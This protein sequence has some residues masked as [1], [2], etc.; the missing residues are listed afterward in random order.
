[1]FILG[2]YIVQGFSNKNIHV[3]ELVKLD[4]V[5]NHIDMDSVFNIKA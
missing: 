4:Q 5:R 1:M 3:N 2:H